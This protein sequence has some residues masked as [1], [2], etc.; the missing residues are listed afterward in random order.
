MLGNSIGRYHVLEQLGEGGMATVYKA[1]DT[2]LEREVAI[3][4]LRTERLDSRKATKRFEIEA[5]A[6]AK[7]NHPNIVQVLDFGEHD[8]TPY[9]VME[10]VPGGT[11]KKQLGKPLPWQQAAQLLA[12]I[13][14]ALAYAH[15]NNLVHRDVKPS[16]ILITSTGIPKLADFGIAKM[17][18]MEE[19]MD[20]TG[21]SVGVG[22]PWY[23]SPEQGKGE[24]IDQRTDIYS[25]GI[26]FYELVTGRKPYQADT[27]MAVIYQHVQD[28]LP[29]PT[30]IVS[31]L[32]SH[33]EQFLFKALAKEPEN[34]FQ[35]MGE[36]ADVLE[37]LGAG[38]KVKVRAP[39]KNTRR[40][41]A[42][43]GGI[44]VVTILVV[45]GM[46]ILPSVPISISARNTETP[47]SLVTVEP[48][49][50]MDFAVAGTALVAMTQVVQQATSDA[51]MATIYVKQTQQ[52]EISDANQ[53]QSAAQLATADAMATLSPVP[54][55]KPTI[56]NTK[57]PDGYTLFK[58]D[59]EDGRV[60][61][62][63]PWDNLW[64]ISIDEN[65]NA[66]YSANA[67]RHTGFTFGNVDW[68]NYAVEYKVRF[69][70]IEP[71]SKVFLEF[72]RFSG[73]ENYLFDLKPYKNNAILGI[74]TNSDWSR[75]TSSNYQFNVNTW[76]LIRVEV[77]YSN[78][79]VFI[80]GNLIIDL[81][82][83]R[84]EHGKLGLKVDPGTYAQ[85]DDFWVIALGQ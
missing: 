61:Y 13:A 72:R 60:Q 81:E 84:I 38:A 3:K 55:L 44:A 66:V 47:T 56:T 19:T 21:T 53:T 20:L 25:L 39:G 63:E 9:L 43:L 57:L 74:V 45:A 48:S 31:S 2:R 70:E 69:T 12:P 67:I 29:R 28:P 32:P 23:M 6:L 36:I 34:R 76:Y 16:N 59:F 4:L 80:D 1:F 5:K 79:S 24:K 65:G 40:T 49:A 37:K 42:V 54:T 52:K 27:P 8:G 51:Q 30:K 33:V 22:T 71:T 83:S 64:D 58:E 68:R 41:L 50:T 62:I 10:Y 77:Y 14:R 26:V 7:L 85:F 78:I 18:E 17:L 35:S 11:L 73:S 46:M 82:D 15:E 75:I